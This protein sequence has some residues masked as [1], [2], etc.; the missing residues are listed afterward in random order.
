MELIRTKQL[1]SY[2][3]YTQMQKFPAFQKEVANK[4]SMVYNDMYREQGYSQFIL[5][6]TGN[7]QLDGKFGFVDWYD[8]DKGQYHA[9]MCRNASSSFDGS[10]SARVNTEHMEVIKKTELFKYNR[11]PKRDE[12]YVG[13]NNSFTKGEDKMVKVR[14]RHDVLNHV[15]KVHPTPER[16]SVI[17]YKTM[18]Q[19]IQEKEENEKEDEAQLKREREDYNRN[20]EIFLSTRDSK[21]ARPRKKSRSSSSQAKD[22]NSVQVQSVWKAKFEHIRDIVNN[23]GADEGEHLFTF[24]FVTTDNSLIEC[25]QGLIELYEHDDDMAFH[26]N[27]FSDV[28]KMDP[29][30]ITTECIKS[31]SPGES[32]EE[33]VINFCLK[34]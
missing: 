28:T 33:D 14:V 29:I 12:C 26:D 6:D 10:T 31:L 32:V 27:C 24:P 18:S 20:M 22:V 9:L 19:M 15:C 1:P 13:I 17:A 3:T 8:S 7:D 11:E 30:I 23:R 2:L 4:A 5:C 25:G 16:S 34:W 21:V